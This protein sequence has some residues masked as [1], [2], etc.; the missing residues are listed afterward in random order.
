MREG[1]L[2]RDW[3]IAAQICY[4][5]ALAFADPKHAKKLR[6]EHFNLYQLSREANKTPHESTPEQ[7][8]YMR[9]QFLRTRRRGGGGN[10]NGQS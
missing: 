8:N 10:N 1:K 9:D 6:R 3:N 5:T 7:R 2:E 4:V